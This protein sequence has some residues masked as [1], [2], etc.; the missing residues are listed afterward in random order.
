M[1]VVHIT[2]DN[3]EE[4]EIERDDA[5]GNA[6]DPDDPSYTTTAIASTRINRFKIE[7]ILDGGK[8][9]KSATESQIGGVGVGVPSTTLIPLAFNLST[10]L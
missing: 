7:Y 10:M 8:Y 9:I 5:T 1:S 4:D 6:N 2:K 3:F